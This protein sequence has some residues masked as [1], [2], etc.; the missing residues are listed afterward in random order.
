MPK[1]IALTHAY[2]A[3]PEA[4]WALA[5]DFDAL[6]TVMEGL[7]SFEGLPDG[8]LQRGQHLEVGV[9]LFGKLPAQPYTMDVI[10]LDDAEMRFKSREAGA[11]VKS[12][13]HEL[14]VVPVGQGC[15]IREQI[16]IDAGLLTPLYV[17]WA[18]YMYKRR[19]PKR[20][21][22]LAQ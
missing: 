18:R 14:Q 6:Q 7:V 16:T 9:S 19:H 17:A 2:E 3:A 22:L 1:T 11:G 13:Q 5:T 21:E 4:V 20:L 12:W 15:E 10:E 8:R